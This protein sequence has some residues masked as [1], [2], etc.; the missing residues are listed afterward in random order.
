MP[1]NLP[2]VKGLGHITAN[3]YYF[4]ENLIHKFEPRI[5]GILFHLNV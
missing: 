4:K 2:I 5:P 3:Q 1:T